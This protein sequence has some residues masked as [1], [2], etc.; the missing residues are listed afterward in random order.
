MFTS[1]RRQG[2]T[3]L[4]IMV[5]MVL[6][7]LVMTIAV[8]RITEQDENKA[9]RVFT[10]TFLITA[11]H[12]Q[13]VAIA[14]GQPVGV[15]F[16][17]PQWQED[18]LNVPW[19]IRW[20]KLLPVVVE[21]TFGIDSSLGDQNVESELL[22]NIAPKVID[23]WVEIEGLPAHQG[24]ADILME[25]AIDGQPYEFEKEAPAILAPH[26]VIL[27]TGEVTPFELQLT[28]SNSIEALETIVIDEWGEI[29]WK[30]ETEY[31]ETLEQRR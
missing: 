5:V 29:I 31:I 25:L 19:K 20:Y 4:E 1:K 15:F 28:H 7:G 9:I 17:P 22:L 18:E 14:S 2:F 11:R 30:E 6:I 12:L 23:T 3:L 16:E 10:D 27:P 24:S 13:D 21:P 26:V 8:V